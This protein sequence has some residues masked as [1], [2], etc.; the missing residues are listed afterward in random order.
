VKLEVLSDP[1]TL[2]PDAEETIK[3]AKQLVSEGFRVLPYTNDDPSPPA[4]SRTP[5]ARPVMPLER[6]SEAGWACATPTRCR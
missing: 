6:R 2:L 1:K 3:A 5:G 4:S